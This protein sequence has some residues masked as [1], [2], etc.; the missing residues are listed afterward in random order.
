[1]VH[2][3]PFIEIQLAAVRALRRNDL[4]LLG[5]RY[6]PPPCRCAGSTL[7]GGRHYGSAANVITAQGTSCA[8][9]NGPN[10]CLFFRLHG[11]GE[12]SHIRSDGAPPRSRRLGAW[13]KYSLNDRFGIFGE[14]GLR[15]EHFTTEGVLSDLTSKRNTWGTRTGVGVI[16]YF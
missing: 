14:L 3:L 15:Y 6:G 10:S 9:A 12:T 11:S 7:R 13:V 2:L 8:R 16:L 4:E 1:M 5:L